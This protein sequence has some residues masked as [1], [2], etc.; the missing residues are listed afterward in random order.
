M[1]LY[2]DMKHSAWHCSSMKSDY[3]FSSTC[4]PGNE[5]ITRAEIVWVFELFAGVLKASYKTL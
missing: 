2:S 3:F 5:I 4:Q 1:G